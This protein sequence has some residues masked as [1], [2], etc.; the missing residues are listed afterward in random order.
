VDG[1]IAIAE[2]A[3]RRADLPDFSMIDS[4]RYEELALWPR[5]MDSDPRFGADYRK[6][7]KLG[8][9][10]RVFGTLPWGVPGLPVRLV[11]IEKLDRTTL[12]TL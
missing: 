6:M 9:L 10:F 8:Y 2:K 3:Q 5:A 7:S 12:A 1:A 4:P 11:S